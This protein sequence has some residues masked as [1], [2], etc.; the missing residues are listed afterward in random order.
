[1]EDTIASQTPLQKDDLSIKEQI[2]KYLVHWKW[3]VLS[4]SIALI[5]AFLFLRY[6]IPVYSTQATIHVQ[7]DQKGGALSESSALEGMGIYSG[8][9]VNNIGN[10]LEVLRSRR[11]M[12]LVVEELGLNLEYHSIGKVITTEK[13]E[14]APLRV[15]FLE[16]KG[17]PDFDTYYTFSM[18]PLSSSSYKLFYGKNDKKGKI[19]LY[20]KAINLGFG[21]FMVVPASETA[22]K[23]IASASE[24]ELI[25]VRMYPRA[26]VV[27]RYQRSVS[28]N[29]KSKSSSVVQLTLYHPLKKKARD[30]INNLIGQ[31]NKD[32]I[33]DRNIIAEHTAN[34]I[35][36]RLKIISQELDSV[37]T[38]K[39]SFKIANNLTDIDS[40]A[41]LFI[42]SESQVQKQLAEVSTQLAL[43]R[44]MLSVLKK[45]P[46]SEKPLPYNIGIADAGLETLITKYNQSILERNRIL[47][48]ATGKNPIVVTIN[49]QLLQLKSNIK[50]SLENTRTSLRIQKNSLYGQQNRVNSDIASVPQKE[51]EFLDIERQRAIKEALYVFLLQK[52]EETSIS[53]TVTAPVAKI[54]DPAYT[55]PGIVSPNRKM[56]FMLAILLGLLIPF[57]IIYLRI[58]LDTKVH[59]SLDLERISGDTPILGELPKFDQ[60]EKE[61]IN[62]ND[63][64]VLAESFRMLRTNLNYLIKTKGGL[65]K[66]KVIYTTS[67]VVGEGKTFVAFN[68]ASTLATNKKKVLLIGADI[69][70]P[71]LQRYTN[72]T[73]TDEGLCEYLYDETLAISNIVRQVKDENTSFDIILSG[74]IPPN[75][76]ELFMSDRLPQ[77]LE[78]LRE[79][80]DYII[81][82]TA[83][84]MLVT[85]TLLI[86]QYADLTLYVARADY[87]E[88]KVL[89]HPVQLAKEG[90]LK[91]IAFIMNNVAQSKFGYN[92]KYEYSY[93]DSKKGF[94]SKVKKMLG[95]GRK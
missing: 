3:F 14:D 73:K 95:L 18:K 66:I 5:A 2:A 11:L 32:A 80:Y 31:Y 65:D 56:F 15:K 28:S 81:V 68:L 53:L 60:K 48:G 30:I 7:D 21:E 16:E 85:D 10:E 50:S 88:K 35:A 46:G 57:A 62:R 90:K 17:V 47:K 51:K 12:S 89:Q 64:S 22:A 43:T 19:V 92:T 34:F 33:G 74:K 25:V 71:Q 78:G 49:D 67:S 39:E 40:E 61:W 72:H 45:N 86:S 94:L 91:N 87:T 23:N 13:Y 63:R 8:F 75:P 38:S 70:N 4:V 9:A 93:S 77:L 44:N 83:P 55:S 84:T 37:E 69:R 41:Q 36:E 59:N 26:S 82:D 27:N 52:R 42:E 54:I 20:G 76:A 79:L 24:P 29:Q 58:L 6:S 1:M